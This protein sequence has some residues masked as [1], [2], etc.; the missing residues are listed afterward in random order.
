MRGPLHAEHDKNWSPPASITVVTTRPGL[1]RETRSTNHA[2]RAAGGGR[3]PVRALEVADPSCV[4][5]Y[6]ERA[7]TRSE[8][9]WEIRGRY[10][11][12]EFAEAEVGLV[13]WVDSRCRTTGMAPWRSSPTRS[14]GS[15]RAT[16][17]CRGD[18]AGAPGGRVQDEAGAAA[19]GGLRDEAGSVN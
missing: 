3:L 15:E 5:R 18:D 6:T 17:S 7:K 2:R 8:R 1:S 19:V 4:K 11:L 9:M 16:C 14:Y 13:T 12:R 10:H